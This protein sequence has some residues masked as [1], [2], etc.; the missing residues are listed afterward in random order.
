MSTCCPP[1]NV[2]HLKLLLLLPPHPT[3][4][5][6]YSSSSSPPS[7]FDLL[8]YLSPLLR[9]HLILLSLLCMTPLYPTV[10]PFSSHK[11]P[12]LA[13]AIC[14]PAIT[15]TV[16][17]TD[18]K[19]SGLFPSS[20]LPSSLLCGPGRLGYA[21]I[22]LSILPYCQPPHSRAVTAQGLVEKRNRELVEEPI[23]WR[24]LWKRRIGLVQSR[25]NR[26]EGKDTAHALM[27]V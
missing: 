4:D 22:T 7:S 14:T 5:S 11:S 3:P 10:P 13:R 15:E 19:L 24:M 25:S 17:S 18:V 26:G 27:C 2:I 6:L 16:C 8:P 9:L 1:R 23:S 21:L 12:T 20:S